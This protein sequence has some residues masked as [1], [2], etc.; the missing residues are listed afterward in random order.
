M[1]DMIQKIRL[2]APSPE[3]R[4]D[5]DLV[6]FDFLGL[7]PNVL[8]S[9]LVQGPF[10]VVTV[11]LVLPPGV[12]LSVYRVFPCLYD[13]EKVE[14]PFILCVTVLRVFLPVFVVVRRVQLA[15]MSYT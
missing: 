3:R 11:Y 10:L 2:T 7:A 13:D 6:T 14:A 12:L 5:L 9:R 4:P 8:V 15:I 1:S